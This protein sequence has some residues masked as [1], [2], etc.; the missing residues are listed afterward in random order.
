M[1]TAAVNL[2]IVPGVMEGEARK[3]LSLYLASANA[4]LPATPRFDE[5]SDLAVA[6]A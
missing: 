6:R 4:S 5:V 2:P 3:K 1:R